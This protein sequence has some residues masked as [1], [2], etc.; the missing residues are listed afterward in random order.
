MVFQIWSPDFQI[1]VEM[2]S[3][4]DS[5]IRNLNDQR[6]GRDQKSLETR[7]IVR[8]LATSM[9]ANSLS[10]HYLVRVA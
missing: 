6:E 2:I 4:W 1:Q 9:L 5:L 10:F 7:T 8:Q 3:V